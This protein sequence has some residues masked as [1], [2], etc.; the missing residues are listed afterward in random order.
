MLPA[1]G[2]ARRC[3]CKQTAFIYFL[4]WP[5]PN[6][7]RAPREG[8]SAPNPGQWP[9]GARS[10]PVL[11]TSWCPPRISTRIGNYDQLPCRT[12][13]PLEKPKRRKSFLSLARAQR[14]KSLVKT[15]YRDCFF[16]QYR[17]ACKVLPT[18]G[19]VLQYLLSTKN[20]RR[21]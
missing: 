6:K 12:T 14:S 20:T 9:L 1:W 4:N 8:R 18:G 16:F 13:G 19:G 7:R 21:G 10:V 3:C 2:H 15:D 11:P 5:I 17:V